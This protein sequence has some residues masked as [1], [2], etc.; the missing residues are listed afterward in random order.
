SKNGKSGYSPACANE[1]NKAVC[2]KPKIK[3]SECEHRIFFAGDG[4]GDF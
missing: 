2:K 4:S 1:W 3:C